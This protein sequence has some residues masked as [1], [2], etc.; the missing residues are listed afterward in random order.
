MILIASTVVGMVS[1]I[2][3]SRISRR[4]AGNIALKDEERIDR[5]SYQTSS[6]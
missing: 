4:L 6:P 2:L 3:P 1:D 5:G